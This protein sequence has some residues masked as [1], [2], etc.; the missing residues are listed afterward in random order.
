M[1]DIEKQSL[2]QAVRDIVRLIPPGRATSYGAIARAA[3]Y[4]NLSRMV[5]RILSRCGDAEEDIP[6]HRVVNSQGMLTARRAFGSG[7]EMQQRLEA[8][9]VAVGNDRILNWKRIFWDPL[10]EI[11]G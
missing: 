3:G 2:A 9:G 5:G 8:E 6:A 7:N 11:G 10:R 4:P 1:D